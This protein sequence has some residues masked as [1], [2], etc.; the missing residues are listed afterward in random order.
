MNHSQYKF[1]EIENCN[2]CGAPATEAAVLGQRLN[3]T[4]GVNPRRKTGISVSV[5]KCAKCSLIYSNPQPIPLNILDHYGIPPD[6]YWPEHYFSFD[7]NYFSAEI[8][9]AKEFLNFNN[10]MSALDIGAGLGK[11][12][13]SLERAGFDTYGI[14]PSHTFRQKAIDKM[15]VDPNRIR[16][17]MLEEMNFDANSFDFITFGAV[18]EHLYDPKSCMT[19]ALSWLKPNGV[20]HIE[21]PSSKW[22]IAKIFNTYFRLRGSNYVTNLSPMHEPFHMHEFSIESFEYSAVDLGYSIL[23]YEYQV[24]EIYHI[25]TLLHPLLKWYMKRSKTGMQLVVWIRK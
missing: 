25:P 4:Q 6:H 7:D 22:L 10:G 13:K 14:E 19:K 18:L 16:E 1:V 9:R 11:C 15:A 24:C 2:M 17:G 21:V 5:L 23:D 3:Q 20:I 12:M 8:S